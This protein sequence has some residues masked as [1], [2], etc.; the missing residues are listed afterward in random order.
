MNLDQLEAVLTIIEKGSFRAAADH[1]HKS[2]PALSASIKNLEEEFDIQIF[3]RSEY[4]PK[5]TEVGSVFINSAKKTLEAS[6]Q[7]LKIAKELGLNKAETKIKV[8][9]DPLTSIEA[10]EIIAHECSRPI[11]PVVLILDR[12]VLEGSHN[13]LIDGSVDLALA[14]YLGHDDIIEKIILEKVTLVPAVSR[15]LLQEKRKADEFFLK[16]N[17]QVFV[18]NKNFDEHAG[19][20]IPNPIYEGGGP[21]IYVPDHYTKLNLI[22]NGLGWG[23]ISQKEFDESEDLV[24]IDK[25][26]CKPIELELCLMKSKQR[27]IGPIARAIWSVFENMYSSKN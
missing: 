6:Q 4:R 27:P 14:P 12:T 22:R 7:T 2:Q 26:I 18:Y 15:K 24:L 19:D 25:K 3:D 5:L 16:K 8:A 10:I 13:L 21:K 11:V 23:R 17:A 1:L 20:L 9:V